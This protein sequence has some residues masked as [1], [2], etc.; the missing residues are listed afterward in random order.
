[1]TIQQEFPFETTPFTSCFTP[2][3]CC[4]PEDRHFESLNQIEISIAMLRAGTARQIA[5]RVAMGVGGATVVGGG[6]LTAYICSEEGLGL[7]RELR[8]WRTVSPIVIDYWW[9][10]SSSSPYQKYQKYIT[11]D[12]G[13]EGYGQKENDKRESNEK[14]ASSRDLLFKELHQ[15]N[16]PKLFQVLLD[17]GGLYIKLGQVL[18]VTALPVP[19]EYRE[20]FR[21]LQSNVPGHEEFES[22]IRPTLEQEFG[23]ESLDDLFESFDEIP[24]GAASIGQA[25]RATLKETGEKI[26]V[27]VQY[28]NAKWQVP[29]DIHCVGDFLKLCVYFGLVDES[30]SKLSYEEFARQFMAELDYQ[31][32]QTNLEEVYKSS[33]DPKAPYLRRGVVI[34]RVFPELCTKQVI[35]MTFLPGPKFEEEAKQQLEMLG[36]NTKKGI[37][38]VV[39]EVAKDA[40]SNTMNS[41]ASTEDGVMVPA[42]KSSASSWKWKLSRS[43][44]NLVGVDSIF[45]L[46]RMARRVMLWSTA[47]AVVSI[48]GLSTLSLAPA[49]WESWAAA[50][51]MAALQ[52]A[53]LDWTKEAVESLLDVHGY[54]ILNQG[55]FNADPHPGNILILTGDG[56]DDQQSQS[57][58]PKLGLIDYGQCKR[59]EAHERVQIAKLILSVADHESDETVALHFRNLGIRTQNDSTEFLAKFARLMFG[60]FRP[61]HLDHSWH[62]A[63]HNQDKVLYFPNELSMV[64]RTSLLLRGL[65]M[66]LQLNVSVGEQ[67]RHHAR[68]AIER[69]GI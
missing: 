14:M 31:R 34:P 69:D 38:S 55:L 24:C 62:Q 3:F 23:V 50:R 52:A 9:N 40:T 29:A 47:A 28:P 5:R 43:L 11:R 64:Y 36:F 46:I 67:W 26:I 12:D 8:F 41:D 56:E 66:S 7:R 10:A 21:T 19:E 44:G 63:M 17:L 35:T 37:R 57:E 51:E 30:A 59:L 42:T 60:S 61:E 54:Q 53:R 1:M 20:L 25:H 48:R 16:A 4:C 45:S 6:V 2:Q 27:K 18:S 39:Q 68:A 32:E 22:V 13:G 49:E 58:N 33:L 65:A 15:R